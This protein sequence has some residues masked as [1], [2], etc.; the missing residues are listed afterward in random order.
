MT[1]FK[2]GRCIS[3]GPIYDTL[4]YSPALSLRP[5]LSCTLELNDKDPRPEV[6]LLASVWC[7]AAERRDV[8][9]R[10]LHASPALQ[11]HHPLHRVWHHGHRHPHSQRFVLY[12]LFFIRVRP[13]G[14]GSLRCAC[15][16]LWAE[17]LVSF[18]TC[19]NVTLRV[20]DCHSPTHSLN[21]SPNF[22]LLQDGAAILKDCFS[23]SFT[24]TYTGTHAQIF[25]HT[26][27][28]Q[29]FLCLFLPTDLY[30]TI[31]L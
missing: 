3:Y 20:S 18:T 17:E 6:H 12:V 21:H 31:Q 29:I 10:G 25:V 26:N 24:L 1:Q 8:C 4:T 14:C 27:I 9:R 11:G 22:Y 13:A 16:C 19:L 7:L 2:F 30:Q 15:P 23:V 5:Q 28:E